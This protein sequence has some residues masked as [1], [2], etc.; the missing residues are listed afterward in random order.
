MNGMIPMMLVNQM[1][2]NSETRNGSHLSPCLPELGPQDLVADEQHAQLAHVLDASRHDLRAPEREPEE[3][4][5]Q[6]RAST[7]STPGLVNCT[8]AI[9]KI[10]LK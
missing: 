7:I 4:H 9:V 5:H 10:G 2:K 8:L 1:K 3:R 6:E